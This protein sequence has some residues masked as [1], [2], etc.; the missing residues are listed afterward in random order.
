MTIGVQMNV[1]RRN[2]DAMKTNAGIKIIYL[3]F[4]LTTSDLL[5]E[6]FITNAIATTTNIPKKIILSKIL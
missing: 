5:I 4:S 2:D 1:M 6:F 3:I